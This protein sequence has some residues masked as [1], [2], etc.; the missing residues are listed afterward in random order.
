ME[1]SLGNIPPPVDSRLFRSNAPNYGY[2]CRLF[3]KCFPEPKPGHL[4]GDKN[5]HSELIY[6][7]EKGYNCKSPKRGHVRLGT[8]MDR[9]SQLQQEDRRNKLREQ[10]EVYGTWEECGQR[11]H[12]VGGCQYWDYEES[13]GWCF[14]WKKCSALDHNPRYEPG[15]VRGHRDCPAQRK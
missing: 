5:C 15:F 12:N 6:C 7:V 8:G 2:E 3:N 1:L 4:Q 13:S 11:C 9:I 10:H 14:F